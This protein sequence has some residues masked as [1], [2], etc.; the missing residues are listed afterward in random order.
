MEDDYKDPMF[1]S[2]LTRG[3][4]LLHRSSQT[5]AFRDVSMGDV[6]CWR[7]LFAFVCHSQ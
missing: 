1:H 2:L 5:A 7:Q 4:C 3:K 6:E